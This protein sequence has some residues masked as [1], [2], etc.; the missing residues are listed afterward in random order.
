MEL[1]GEYKIKQEKGE[2]SG[3][4]NYKGKKGKKLQHR[5]SHWNIDHQYN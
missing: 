3:R 5:L 2:M 1:L 4:H